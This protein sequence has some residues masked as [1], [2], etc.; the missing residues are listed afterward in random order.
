VADWATIRQE[1]KELPSEMFTRVRFSVR[2]FF[3]AVNGACPPRAL[4]DEEPRPEHWTFPEG[5]FKPSAASSLLFSTHFASKMRPILE[6]AAE[7]FLF[8]DTMWRPTRE[9]REERSNADKARDAANLAAFMEIVRKEIIDKFVYLTTRRLYQDIFDN[10]SRALIL[11]TMQIGLRHRECQQE[12]FKYLKDSRLTLPELCRSLNAI[13]FNASTRR[14]AVNAVSA[15]EDNPP[16][17]ASPTDFTAPPDGATPAI[18]AVRGGGGR[19][20]RR[21]RARG[22]SRGGRGGGAQAA[23][24][25]ASKSC[26]WCQRTGHV[27]SECRTKVREEKEAAASKN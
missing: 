14:Q 13:Q 17:R 2:T 7:D 23:K 8:G 9:E 24:F 16:E 20:G 5:S 12:A 25:D 6:T 3:T 1:P 19:G 27:E 10:T 22:A 4:N 18:N 21:G 11:R 26:D 15:P